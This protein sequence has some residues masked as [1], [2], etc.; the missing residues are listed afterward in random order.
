MVV[1]TR[2]VQKIAPV[3]VLK[4]EKSMFIPHRMHINFSFFRTRM[5]NLLLIISMSLAKH[6]LAPPLYQRFRPPTPP[7]QKKK[8]SRLTFHH[9]ALQFK[10][11]YA[12][13]MQSTTMY[14]CSKIKSTQLTTYPVRLEFSFRI[15]FINLQIKTKSSNSINSSVKNIFIDIWINSGLNINNY[16]KPI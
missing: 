2:Y 5:Q 15:S 10:S 7:P 14:M 12:Y 16:L 6:H 13:K 11:Q 1:Q 3:R 4:K 9:S 8:F